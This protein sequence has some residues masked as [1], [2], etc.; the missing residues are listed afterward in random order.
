[1]AL[2]VEEFEPPAV[3]RDLLWLIED[4]RLDNDGRIAP[5]FGN[6]ME[7][8]MSGRIG[9]T[10]TINGRVLDRV[11]VKAGERLRLRIVNAMLA[12]IIGLRFAEHRPIVVAYDGQP[13]DPHPLEGGR[14][15]LGPAMRADLIVDMAGTP[16][17]T[18]PVTDD[19]YRDLAY[20]LL[21]LA[22]DPA[23]PTQDRQPSGPAK[24]PGNPLP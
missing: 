21:D 13:C 4:W 12:R 8:G 16:G 23:K 17:R 7:A 3:D 24:L 5:G 11:S 15:V 18:Y 19:F 6:R 14:L 9:N 1:G 10:V 2:I 22:Y 20:T